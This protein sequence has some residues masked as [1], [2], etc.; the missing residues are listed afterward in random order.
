MRSR[1]TE[2]CARASIPDPSRRGA[3]GRQ[4]RT[5]RLPRGR[6]GEAAATMGRPGGVPEWPKG[7]GCKP[8]GSA[9]GGSNPPAPTK[10][11]D[12]NRLPHFAGFRGPRSCRSWQR[13]RKT[14]L[15]TATGR[16]QSFGAGGQSPGTSDETPKVTRLPSSSPAHL[17]TLTAPAPSISSCVYSG[18][19]L[20]RTWRPSVLRLRSDLPVTSGTRQR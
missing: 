5:P 8:V 17:H 6:A 9:Y 7:T 13:P 2:A 18:S 20:S 1:P 12:A 10:G 4:R 19:P 15:A 3:P 14:D 16:R 11:E